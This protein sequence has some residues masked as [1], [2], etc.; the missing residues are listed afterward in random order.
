MTWK[1][2]L[3]NVYVKVLAI[4]ALVSVLTGFGLNAAG[5]RPVLLFEHDDLRD[6][7]YANRCE[8]LKN[9]YAKA[10]IEDRRIK[11]TTGKHDNYMIAYIIRLEREMVRI[12]C[13]WQRV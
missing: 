2:I 13:V 4:G 8:T 5:L 7:V 11:R 12:K 3:K 6:Y 9:E 1:I 10:R